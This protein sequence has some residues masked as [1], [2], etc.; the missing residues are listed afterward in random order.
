MPISFKEAQC[1]SFRIADEEFGALVDLIDSKIKDYCRSYVVNDNSEIYVAIT[2]EQYKSTNLIT[3]LKSIYKE[4]NIS[5]IPKKEGV[6]FLGNCDMLCF[7]DPSR[8]I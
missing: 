8:K 7:K 3:Y 1:L 6:Y 5:V 2:T 4:W